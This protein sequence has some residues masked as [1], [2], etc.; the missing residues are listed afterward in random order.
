MK[1]KL[2]RPIAL[3][4]LVT[5][6]PVMSGCFGSFGATRLVWE[7]NR[8]LFSNKFLQWIL[9]I[10]FTALPVYGIAVTVDVFF[11]NLLEF[12]TGSNLLVE[13]G[14][15][16]PERVVQLDDD[17]IMVMNRDGYNSLRFEMIQK[18][19]SH[20]FALEMKRDSVALTE[21]DDIVALLRAEPQGVSVYD[22]EGKLLDS[23][24]QTE[25]DSAIAAY[26]EKGAAGIVGWHQ[27]R[28]AF[29]HGV[30]TR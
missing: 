9:F 23:M 18:G 24:T 3:A 12:W 15:D 14:E 4:L 26:E 8:D 22:A 30:A 13:K 17:T 28:E 7:L 6:T 21:G 1:R 2:I 25:Q 29:E 20:N 16:V 27:T 11:L 19:E 10:V 5:V